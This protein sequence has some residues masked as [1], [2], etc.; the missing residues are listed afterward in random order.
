M[1]PDLIMQSI[2]D[3]SFD[4]EFQYSLMNKMVL[5]WIPNPCRKVYK[6]INSPIPKG[7]IIWQMT[8]HVHV[9]LDL[10]LYCR[11]LAPRCIPIRSKIPTLASGEQ[12]FRTSPHARAAAHTMRAYVYT[13]VYVR[14]TPRDVD[15]TDKQVG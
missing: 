15:G 4:T 11:I 12:I 3:S 14:G 1:N 10:V 2:H 13:R 6:Y 9:V 8:V 7:V 5:L